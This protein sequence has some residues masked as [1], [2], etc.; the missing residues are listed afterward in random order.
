ME[1]LLY[2]GALGIA[3]EGQGY[4]DLSVLRQ[5]I[6]EARSMIAAV[7][8]EKAVPKGYYTFLD[9]Q[10]RDYTKGNPALYEMLADLGFDYLV[11]SMNPGESAVQYRKGDF[12]SINMSPPYFGFYSNFIRANDLNE[13]DLCEDRLVEF[14]KPGWVLAALD[15]PIWGFENAPWECGPELRRIAEYMTGGG[16]SGRLINVTP[17]T[18]ARYARILNDMSLA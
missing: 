4:M 9:I 15:S 10:L 17:G 18:I 11:S 2:T 8:G 3:A 5:N 14:D 16:N 1:P 7:A 12:V 13:I 6:M